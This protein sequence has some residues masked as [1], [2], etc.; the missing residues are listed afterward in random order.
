MTIEL[1]INGQVIEVKDG[2]SVLD[3]INQSGTYISQL[4]KDPDMKP[5]GACRTCLV[6]IDGQRGYP[7]SCSIPASK[8]MTIWTNTP[9][10]TEIRKG[11]IELTLGMLP[12]QEKNY[13]ELS[14][15]AEHHNISTPIWNSRSRESKDTMRQMCDSLPRRRPIHRSHRCFRH[16]YRQQDWNIHGSS[17]CR[18]R[19]YN[20]WP[21]PVCVPDRSYRGKRCIRFPNQKRHNN[22]S[23]LWCRM[24]Y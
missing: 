20:L 17:T 24:W 18:I 23:L 8:G 15:A 9:E 10:V 1:S 14:T 12:Q 19:M 5:L 22:M 4:C 21:V 6:Q 7:A 16:R 11:V 3:A 2:A 13:K